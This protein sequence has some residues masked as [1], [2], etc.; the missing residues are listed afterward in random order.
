MATFKAIVEPH[1]KR[2][3]N[4]YN[5]KIRVIHQTKKRY[6]STQW[7]VT[8]KDMTPK[9]KLKT[10]SFIDASED[11]IREYRKQ[12][13]SLGERIKMMDVGQLVEELTSDKTPDRFDLDFVQFVKEEAAKLK[14]DGRD[15]TSLHYTTALNSLIRFA[16]SD[17]ISIHNITQSF[18]QRYIDYLVNMP[19]LPNKVRGTRAQ[20]SYPSAI[21]A[22]HNKAKEKYNDEDAGIIRIPLSPFGKLKIP[23]VEQSRKRAIS[24]EKIQMIINLPYIAR[25]GQEPGEYCR[26]NLAKDIFLLSFL[27]VGMNSADLYNCSTY[28]SGVITYQRTKTKTRRADKAEI[29]ITVPAQAER[30]IEKYR[31]KTGVRVFS[32]YQH[33]STANAFNANIN[34][35]LKQI[36]A[37]I[38]CDDLEFYAARHSW[39][40]IAL[41]VA[42]IDK[43]TV[44]TALNHVDEAMKMTD[45]YIEKDFSII[46]KANDKV[47]ELFEFKGFDPEKEF[48]QS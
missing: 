17:K 5:I 8:A 11:L 4:T 32:F 36:G 19:A 12:C 14:K 3:D 33:Y 27:L 48:D 10:Q 35:L 28:K 40:T 45:I 24:V 43:Y 37:Q 20:S 21:R 16:Q 15:G 47:L 22:L 1:Y 30:L 29:K 26:F 9:L 38:E 42:G 13:D 2:R 18:M 34:K 41:N 23:K 39:A 44:H 31:D 46:A 7:Y 6:I 25:H